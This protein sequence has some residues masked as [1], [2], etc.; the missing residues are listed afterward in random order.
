MNK[1]DVDVLVV[2]G[3]PV[4]LSTAVEL[5]RHGISVL[6]VERRPDTSAFP[7]ARL[8]TTRT[9]EI[10]RGWGVHDEVERTGMPR[11]EYLAVGVGSSLTAD[12]FVRS[13]AEL[14]RD[15]PQSPTYTFLCAQDRLEVIL[16]RLAES[17]P[18]ADVW[19]G[20]TMTGMSATADGVTA[21]VRRTGDGTTPGTGDG[22]TAGG[23]TA[24]GTSTTAGGETVVRCR[25]LVAADGSRSGVREDLGIAVEG[26][27]PLGHMISIMFEADLGFLP[28]DR[29][30]ALSFL[31][32]PPCAVEA[33]DHER[34]WMVQTGYEPELGGSPADF[35]EE[36]CLAA[37]RAA[38]GVPDLPV[39][40]LGVMP[41]LQQAK[42]A[43]A[44][45]AGP[46]FLAGDAA[47]VATPQGGFG[48]NCGIQDAHN[49]A[50]KLAAVLR[51]TAGE[52]LLDTYEAE[53]RPV[54][55]RT[56]D[57]S[58]NNALITFAM[59]EGRLSMREAIER[60][61]G[62]RSCEGLVLGFGYDSGAVLPDG[63]APPAPA[64]PYRTYVPTARPGHR[65]PHVWLHG[66]HGRVSTLDLLGP[67]FTLLAPA[68]A[69]WPAAATE[70]ARLTGVP[71]TVAEISDADVPDTDVPNTGTT[72][73]G[74][75]RPPGPLVSP[76]W[77][78]EYE[79]G[80]GGAV[81]VRPDGHVAWR[82]PGGPASAR[83]LTEAL[84]RIL[85]RR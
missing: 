27:P 48:M 78:K 64:D 1:V 13:A 24:T 11:E 14:E 71:L 30:A 73:A 28:P 62:R 65:A 68:G 8:I 5:A 38:V 69:G 44:F 50:W 39:T 52:E 53:R 80:P 79:L 74:A 26:P 77:A 51:G 35:T 58:L 17:R 54:A 67:H 33:V 10:L 41:W 61:A 4:G 25:Y 15:A 76:T 43:T 66:P 55:V 3:G 34:R 31:S 75:S 22:T 37:V 36:V 59:M 57:E 21:T 32:D 85:S 42:V 63:T 40:V 2:G 47:H 83:T 56:V 72:G 45:R 12:D 81:L 70:T 9:M 60:Q 7:K 46:V 49:L 84:G 23:G 19:F 6:L 18:E 82:S 29:R 16:R 20:A